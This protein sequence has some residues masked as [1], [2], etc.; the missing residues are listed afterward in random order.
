MA[1]ASHDCRSATHT[2]HDLTFSLSLS[3]QRETEPV[4]IGWIQF[5]VLQGNAH[6]LKEKRNAI[7]PL[8]ADLR[9]RTE[10]AIA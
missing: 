1:L 2:S 3:S 9:L 10:C 5:D 6:S 7:R 4:W 8:I